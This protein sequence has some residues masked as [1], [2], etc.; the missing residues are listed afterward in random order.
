MRTR[1][2]VMGCG[3]NDSTTR[4]QIFDSGKL[5][6]ICPYY[7]M[8]KSMLTRCYNPR[9]HRS[10]PTY[11]GC[12][13]SE[14]FRVLSNFKLWVMEQEEL[15]LKIKEKLFLDKDIKGD[16]L[17]YSPS[18]CLLIPHELN[19]FFLNSGSKGLPTGVDFHKG[20]YRARCANGTNYS[21]N[22]GVFTSPEE[23]HEAWRKA[24][25]DRGWL[26]A[27]K[28]RNLHGIEYFINKLEAL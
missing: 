14:D 20:M 8:W 17:L 4:V 10:M 6:W 11:E 15:N 26:L 18:N 22:I 12:E 1:G 7:K 25:R 27:D 19:S 24:K 9:V 2:V 16:G 3:I 23:A 13:V 28:Y 5:V 21:P